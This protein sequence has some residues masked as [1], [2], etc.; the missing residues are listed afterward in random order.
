MLANLAKQHVLSRFSHQQS[1][2]ALPR[3]EMSSFQVFLSGLPFRSDLHQFCDAMPIILYSCH[4]HTHFW[5]TL[6]SLCVILMH[7]CRHTAC[8]DMVQQKNGPDAAA[9]LR[10]MLHATTSYE[11]EAKA[12][13]LSLQVYPSSASVCS[14]SQILM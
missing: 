10:A 7:V 8:I 14:Q 13:H 12:S 9:V 1:S 3:R 11:T 5:H 2:L 6:S 4:S